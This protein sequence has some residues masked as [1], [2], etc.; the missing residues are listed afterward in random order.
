MLID[1]MKV[2]CLEIRPFD[3]ESTVVTIVPSWWTHIQELLLLSF[4][5]VF[6][7]WTWVRSVYYS[8][9]GRESAWIN[10]MGF[11]W[12][13]CPS[14]HPVSCIKEVKT[15]QRSIVVAFLGILTKSLKIG[16]VHTRMGDQKLC[17]L[18]SVGRE[19]STSQMAVKLCGREVKAGKAYSIYR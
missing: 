7:R 14:C 18:P 13:R 12:A 11:L 19:M 9:S 10:G 3:F 15:K 8:C 1:C 4:N 6:F 16:L 2:E 17:P 5:V